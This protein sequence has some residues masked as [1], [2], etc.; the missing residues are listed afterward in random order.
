MQ[1]TQQ[2][3]SDMSIVSFVLGFLVGGG[4]V[5]WVAWWFLRDDPE[6]MFGHGL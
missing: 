2:G 4:C 5:A 6:G 1:G 3:W